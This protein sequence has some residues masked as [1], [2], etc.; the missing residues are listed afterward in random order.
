MFQYT[1]HESSSPASASG[2][3]ICTDCGA[4]APWSS[5]DAD[6]SRRTADVRRFPS[7]R[8]D[9]YDAGEGDALPCA[10]DGR[11]AVTK[12]VRCYGTGHET[13]S[14]VCRDCGGRGRWLD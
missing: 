9:W 2:E 3:I 5:T 7:T 13:L 14:L 8:K 11:K 10:C 6:Q 12:C 4:R 1:R